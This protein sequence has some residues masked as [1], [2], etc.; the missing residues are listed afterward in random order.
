MAPAHTSPWFLRTFIPVLAAVSLHAPWYWLQGHDS[1]AQLFIIHCRPS[2]SCS[3]EERS[4]AGSSSLSCAGCSM[5]TLSIT[6]IHAKWGALNDPRPAEHPPL[7]QCPQ[8]Q[9][10]GWLMPPVPPGLPTD[11][12]GSPAPK[13]QSWPSNCTHSL[14]EMM[15]LLVLDLP[16][17]S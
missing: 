16:D 15:F 17:T 6:W 12:K 1:V 13:V 8:V 10:L 11:S 7:Q 5:A 9:Q 14:D 2:K 4:S 3:K